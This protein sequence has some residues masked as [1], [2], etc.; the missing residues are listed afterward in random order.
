MD[1]FASLAMT[2]RFRS[3]AACPKSMVRRINDFQQRTPYVRSHRYRTD[4]AMARIRKAALWSAII[5]L[6]SWTAPVLADSAAAGDPCATP[7]TTSPRRETS[8]LQI[9]RDAAVVVV[10]HAQKA[11]AL[12]GDLSRDYSPKKGSQLAVDLEAVIEKLRTNVL[13]HIYREYPDLRGKDL[14]ATSFSPSIEGKDAAAPTMGPATAIYLRWAFKD[15]QEAF[16]KATGQRFCY[17][18]QGETCLH[19]LLDIDSEIGFAQNP[20]YRSFPNLRRLAMLEGE[21]AA[22]AQPHSA[23]ADAT[24]RKIMPKAGSVKLSPA[25]ATFIRGML[26]STRRDFGPKCQ[27]AAIMWSLGGEKK[28][29]SDADWIKIPPGVEVGEYGCGQVPSDVVQTID[30]I[31]IIF[32]G[33]TAVR[34]EGKLVD[35]DGKRFLIKDQ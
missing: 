31:R 34:F 16:L 22:D 26:A 11:C 24:Y 28:G 32:G 5:L 30:G 8:R 12:I 33:D 14:T 17:D 3:K 18:S 29:P 25:A 20:A 35:F 9:E 15:T 6:S 23:E 10:K 7:R 4:E 21:K 27:V 2:Q 13:E 1:C 19:A